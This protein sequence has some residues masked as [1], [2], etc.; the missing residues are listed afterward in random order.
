M[1]FTSSYVNGASKDFPNK[2]IDKSENDITDSVSGRRRNTSGSL[3]L[4]DS[5]ST[6]KFPVVKNFP[7]KFTKRIQVPI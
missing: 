3:I 1:G 5:R 7:L 6:I 2:R 4:F